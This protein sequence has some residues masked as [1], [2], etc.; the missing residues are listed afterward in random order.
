MA[1]RRLKSASEAPK[2]AAGPMGS[3]TMRHALEDMELLGH[4]LAGDSWAAWRVLLIAAMG[5]VLIDDE[6]IIFEALTGRPHEPG[7]RLEELWCVT[8]D[9]AAASRAP[10][11][12]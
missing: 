6:R 7:E 3:V 4:V 12:S 10:S 2:A 5:E 9:A 8:S 1:S 11:R